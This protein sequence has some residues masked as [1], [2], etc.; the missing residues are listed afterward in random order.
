MQ[1]LHDEIGI[2]SGARGVEKG[3]FN[4]QESLIVLERRARD[5]N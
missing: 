4:V 1:F 2:R 5:V 3:Q